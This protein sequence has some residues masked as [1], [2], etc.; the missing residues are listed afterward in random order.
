[1]ARTFHDN[2]NI[3]QGAKVGIKAITS[4]LLTAKAVTFGNNYE[5]M[6]EKK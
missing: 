3:G 6:F 1:M 5:I 4:C 2:T